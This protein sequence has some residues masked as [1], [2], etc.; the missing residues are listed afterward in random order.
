MRFFFP[1]ADAGVF[2]MAKWFSHD[3]ESGKRTFAVRQGYQQLD[4][5]VPG[6]SVLQANPY[7]WDD[8]Y[9]G[10]YGQRQTASFDYLCGAVMG[11][12]PADCERMQAQ[13]VPLFNDPTLSR[14]LDIDQ[15]CEAWGIDV[16]VGKDSDPIFYDR[17]TWLWGRAALVE[18]DRFRAV[19]CGS[20]RLAVETKPP[21]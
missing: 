3:N 17:G 2:S 6:S 19:P 14:A 7:Y 21:R 4:Q 20:K 8:I 10:L 15:V 5:I 16:L 13:L 18:N 11:G 9:H 12:D 1:L